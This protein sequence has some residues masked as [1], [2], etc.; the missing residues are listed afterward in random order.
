MY[1]DESGLLGEKGRKSS[2]DP[3]AIYWALAVQTQIS[4]KTRISSHRFSSVNK[5]WTNPVSQVSA[6]LIV[7][8]LSANSTSFLIGFYVLATSK[9]IL[10]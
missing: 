9:V 4:A 7:T 2:R 3:G 5:S 6:I 1:R 8:V 10:Q